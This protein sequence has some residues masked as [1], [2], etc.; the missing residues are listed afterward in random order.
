MR[1]GARIRV[2]VDV[3]GSSNINLSEIRND[4]SVHTI[5]MTRKEARQV[6]R[7]LLCYADIADQLD[8]EWP[9]ETAVILQAKEQS[10]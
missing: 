1:D 7:A 6:S 3:L 2:H 5:A 10:T 8:K 9:D 4:G